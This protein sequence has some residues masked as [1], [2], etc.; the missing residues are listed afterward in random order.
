MSE[1]VGNRSADP[2]CRM[3]LI[4]ADALINKYQS[5]TTVDVFRYE[6]I[7]DLN[8]APTVDI[9]NQTGIEKAL[10]SIAIDMHKQVRLMQELIMTLEKMRKGQR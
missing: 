6:V 4:D 10:E 2:G 8:N 7:E 1:D 5:E 3:R 9:A